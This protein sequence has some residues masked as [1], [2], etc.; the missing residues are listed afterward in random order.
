MEQQDPTKTKL[1]AG[2]LVITFGVL[3]LLSQIG[4]HIPKYLYS[5]EVILMV[6]GFLSL[7]KHKFRKTWGYVLIA[8]G[9]VFL[10]ND[11]YPHT[12]EMRFV[13]PAII[14]IVGF[15]I[16]LKSLY[17]E[18]N[19]KITVFSEEKDSVSGSSDD[20]I[21][22]TALFGGVTKNIVSKNFQGAQISTIFGGTEL[23]LLHADFEESATIDIT[24]VFGGVSL[25][26]P[27]QWKVVS[28]VTTV[29]GGIDEKRPAQID[30][31]F[32]KTLILKGSCVFG[33]IEI[34]NYA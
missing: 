26:I 19:P 3:I 7:V 24:C 23:N 32:K 8:V 33:G 28:E 31:E 18:K 30:G 16:V 2:L 15:S 21:N 14:I 4:F 17:R 20:F 34:A 29:F 13:Y 5:W 11:F 10:L 27:A 9:G 6:I 12:I 22:S 25:I 1:L